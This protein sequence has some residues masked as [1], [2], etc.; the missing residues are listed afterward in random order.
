MQAETKQ[1]PPG[2][3]AQD[4]LDALVRAEQL[5]AHYAQLPSM[6][7]A[8]TAGALFTAWVL[9]DAVDNRYL[10]VG[11][12][13]VALLSATRLWLYRRY[14]RIAA[15]LRGASRW[16]L[17]AVGGALVSGCVW[18]S[19]APFL[20]PPQ[21]PQY[22]VYLVAL[23]TLLPI[24]PVA[25]LAAYLPAFYAY[26]LP[27]LTPFIVTL[28]LRPSRAEQLTA[29]LLVMMLLA[30]LAF[31]R[32][33]ARSLADAIALRVQLARQ[34]DALQA[35]IE[36]KTRFIATASHD[37]RQ[38]VHAM[39]LLL[40][41]LRG[42]ADPRIAE[43]VRQLEASQRSLRA[44]LGNLLDISR[45][46]AKV[47]EPQVRNFA[48]APLLR[49]L[50]EEFAAQA[51]SKGLVLRCRPGSAAVRSD[52]VL[53]ERI[54]RNLLG[55]ALKYTDR[56]GVL[57]ACRRCGDGVLLQV[58]DTGPGIAPADID[59]IFD[60]FGHAPSQRRHDAEGLG[61]G[62]AIVQQSASLL[63]HTLR[64]RSVPGRGSMFGI[65]V[66][67]APHAA[68]L[69]EVVADA[70]PRLPGGVAWIVDDHEAVREGTAALLRQWGLRVV[71]VASFDQVPDLLVRHPRGP[72]LVLADY[73]LAQGESGLTGVQRMRQRLGREVPAILVSGDTA[74]SR[75][76]EVHVAGH[77]LLHKPV[78]PALL[79]ACLSEALAARPA[80]RARRPGEVAPG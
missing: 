66:T 6:A 20:Y 13:V 56:G 49:Q 51:A 23:L 10:V 78:D 38:P 67:R 61:L 7:I 54:L 1:P 69:V 37:L 14:M 42:V 36:H 75:I 72:D 34:S 33:Y 18:G 80:P 2:G 68:P 32:R 17:I 60:S 16:R 30:M 65:V 59:A 35:A 12:S 62:L 57:L 53:L 39:G 28:A 70:A 52:P 48:V 55:N 11:S 19:V 58:Y 46:E 50:G 21:Q 47:V 27:C 5:R 8:Q 40:E 25:A 63:G 76:R 9:W 71:A 79:R 43:A 74:P 29:L 4:E 15:E 26:Y 24:V 73:R 45:L 3:A 41:M 44:M 22:A 64:L 31:A 77:V